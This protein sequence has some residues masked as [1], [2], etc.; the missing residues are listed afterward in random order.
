MRPTSKRA[1]RELAEEKRRAGSARAERYRFEVK[2]LSGQ[3]T[4]YCMSVGG[5]GDDGS[6]RA[7]VSAVDVLALC[8]L[9]IALPLQRPVGLVLVFF[10][11]LSC[12]TRRYCY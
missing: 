8:F 11:T 1:E 3:A 12:L 5:K 6:M 2:K 4:Q 7:L 9:A 10:F